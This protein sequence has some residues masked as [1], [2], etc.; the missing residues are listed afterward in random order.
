MMNGIRGV[1]TR[2]CCYSTYDVVTIE[3][4]FFGVRPLAFRCS[5]TAPVEARPTN[6]CARPAT[7]L[8]PG[9]VASKKPSL[10]VGTVRGEVGSQCAYHLSGY[11]SM[12][13]DGSSTS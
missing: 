10:K 2:S 5:L 13:I 1:T 9:T 12:C 6:S 8:L 3:N 4:Y 11:R 7:N